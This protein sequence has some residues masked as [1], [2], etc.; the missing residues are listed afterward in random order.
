MIVSASTNKV[1]RTTG[2]RNE[3]ELQDAIEKLPSLLNP[4]SELNGQDYPLLILKREF[5]V[6][7]GSVDFLAVDQ[8]GALYIIETKLAEN[9]ESRRAVIGQVLEYA[10]NLS[11]MPYEAITDECREYLK[12]HG[13]LEQV[14]HNF[15]ARLSAVEPVLSAEDYRKAIADNLNSRR[16]NIVIVANKVNLE[17]QRLFHFVDQ[18]TKDNLNFIVLEINTYHLDSDEVLH[19]GIVWAAKYIRSLFSRRR[20]DEEAYMALKSAHVRELIER[21]DSACQGKGL[22]KTLNTKGLSWKHESGGSIFVAGDALSTNWSTLRLKPGESKELD[23]FKKAKIEDAK[24]A[25][26]DEVRAKHG[27]FRLALSGNVQ[28][29]DVDRF[30]DLAYSVLQKAHEEADLR[31]RLQLA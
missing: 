11:D 28:L 16:I 2:F 6:G 15:Y 30:V 31:D 12:E 4:I 5:G 25:G 20:I 14:V 7:S 21:I 3:K 19:S 8:D 24:E 13:S 17:I 29:K 27:G 18:E 1:F 22:S 9:P 26:F 10:S 23:E